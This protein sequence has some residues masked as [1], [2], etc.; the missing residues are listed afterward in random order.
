MTRQA[1][2]GM[3]EDNIMQMIDEEAQRREL[4]K[5]DEEFKKQW[6]LKEAVKEQFD[7]G[8]VCDM[9]CLK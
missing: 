1:L 4:V 6:V 9:G 7:E 3:K 8:L 2:I 5:K